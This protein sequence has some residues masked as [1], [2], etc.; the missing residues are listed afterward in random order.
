MDKLKLFA[1]VIVFGS[2]WG[3]AECIIGPAL[4]NVDLPSGAIMT[5]FFAIS[6]MMMSRMLY[7]QRGMQLGMG[8]VAGTLRLFNP[9]GGCLICSAIAIVSE[10]VIF[11]LI[12]YK[13]PLDL[14]ELKTHTMTLS[15]GIVSAY[16]CFVGGYIVTQ[17]LT[18]LVSSAGFYI[19]DLV[20]FMPQILSRGLV[21]ALIGGITIPAVMLLKNIEIS[22]IKDKIYYPTTA[23]ISMLCWIVVIANKMLFMG[24]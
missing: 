14:K 23:V 13:M 10:G 11:E 20:V 15:M 9:F 19:G 6:L 4:S 22:S 17:I 1:G 24:A 5:G 21:A 16:C 3:F 18:P 12:W 7:K 2:I 8:L